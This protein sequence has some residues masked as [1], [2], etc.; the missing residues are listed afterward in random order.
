MGSVVQPPA[1]AGIDW[2]HPAGRSRRALLPTTCSTGCGT[3]FTLTKQPPRFPGR[4]NFMIG[5]AVNPSRS[6]AA[7]LGAALLFGASTPFA[8][9]LVGDMPPVL[10]AGLLYLGSGVGLGVFRSLRERTIGIPHLS[11]REWVWL[12]GAIV[13]GGILGPVLLMVGLSQ[14]SAS[15]ASLLL[16]QEA[17]LTA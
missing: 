14:T 2:G 9:Q 5:I 10:L 7:A 6:A 8:K 15:H 16:N 12:L 17:G 3:C 1:T 13:S 11:G 4:F